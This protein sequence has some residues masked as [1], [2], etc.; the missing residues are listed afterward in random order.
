MEKKSVIRTEVAEDCIQWRAL[1][2]AM[3]N[4][5]AVLPTIEQ[6]SYYLIYYSTTNV[7]QQ[8]LVREIQIIF[9]AF[10]QNFPFELHF[11][12]THLNNCMNGVLQFDLM[13]SRR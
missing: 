6:F 2:P 9:V 5:C 11:D 7:W 3:L 4:V 13:M 1:L 10:L 8:E 12:E